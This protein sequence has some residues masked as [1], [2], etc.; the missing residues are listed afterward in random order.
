MARSKTSADVVFIPNIAPE[1]VNINF[2]RANNTVYLKVE[3]IIDYINSVANTEETV[4]RERLAK[5][6]ENLLKIGQ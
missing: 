2:I 4:V 5:L 3:D 1:I 6:T